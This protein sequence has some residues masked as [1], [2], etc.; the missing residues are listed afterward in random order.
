MEDR[1]KG[2][3]KERN[4]NDMKGKERTRKER[5]ETQHKITET[6]NER[7][8]RNENITIR[9]RWPASKACTS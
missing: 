6:N 9:A 8:E 4:G 7:R 2:I 5:K 3:K 1:R